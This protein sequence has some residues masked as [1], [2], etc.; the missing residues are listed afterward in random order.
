MHIEA[1]AISTFLA[2]RIRRFFSATLASTQP[3]ALG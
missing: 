3:G 2:A 1:P